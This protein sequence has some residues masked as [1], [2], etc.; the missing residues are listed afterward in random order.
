MHV[1]K[2]ANLTISKEKNYKEYK[3][4]KNWVTSLEENANDGELSRGTLYG[5]EY[6]FPM[7]LKAVSQSDDPKNPDELIEEAVIDPRKVKTRL[8]QGFVY[9]KNKPTIDYNSAV[10][11]IYGTVR[12]FYSHNAV[13]MGKIKSLA[14]RA[15]QV[16]S[17][18]KNYPMTKIIEIKLDDNQIIRKAIIDRDLFKEIL[19][20][21]NFRDQV[22]FLCALSSGI[23][24]GDLLRITVGD[25]RYQE[26]QHDRFFISDFRSKSGEIIDTFFSKEA[27]RLLRRYYKQEREF[28]SDDEPVFVTEL[29]KRKATFRTK[30]GRNFTP[31]DYELL[32]RGNALSRAQFSV[33]VRTG[34]SHMSITLKP[35]VQQ[36]FRPKRM[37]KEFDD[38]CDRAGVPLAFK[39]IFTG[40]KYSGSKEYKGRSRHALEI[41]Y[42]MVEPEITV[43][44][45]ISHDNQLHDSLKKSAS[46]EKQFEEYKK[47]QSQDQ[48]ETKK[49]LDELLLDK[50]RMELK[51][52][53]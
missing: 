50:K 1:Q 39:K 21:F 4:Y 45:E 48:L 3:S 12:G 5:T 41:Y 52:K 46:L 10:I 38:A 30:Y 32:P 9:C 27:T 16:A 40:K 11:G 14:I 19:S 13:T 24:S 2:T 18:D 43:F 53:N 20:H 35:G 22:I 42:E 33:N 34:V 6:W 47:Q 51:R 49:I 36:P 15:R 29:A 25:V 23:D 28:A 8:H 26:A 44:T 17:T 37:R 7:F 31:S